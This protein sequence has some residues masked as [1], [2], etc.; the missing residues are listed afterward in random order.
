MFTCFGYGSL[1]N[2][3]T[4]S[5]ASKVAPGR[6]KGWRRAWRHSGKTAYGG[7]CTL[8]VVEDEACEIWGAIVAIPLA[9]RPDLDRR[10]AQYDAVAPPGEHVTW[11]EGRP[12]GWPDPHLYVG[13][14]EYGRPGDADNPIMLSYLDV[15]IAGFHAAYGEEGVA[16]FLETTAEWHVPIL[17]DRAAPRYPRALLLS[18]RERGIVDE[19]IKAAGAV[20]IRRG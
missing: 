7:R 2:R 5:E 12:Q 15:V 19:A 13:H 6:L 14:A 10:E 20:K 16:H 9:E 4:L 3:A 11:F 8:T 17:N 1:V 18:E